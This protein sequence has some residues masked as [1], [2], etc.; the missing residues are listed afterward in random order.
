[1]PFIHWRIDTAALFKSSPCQ[2]KNKKALPGYGRT[3][4][5]EKG[6]LRVAFF[7]KLS[8]G[9]LCESRRCYKS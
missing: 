1:M 2:H 7:D 8:G 9:F 4:L 6:H 3:Q 5:V